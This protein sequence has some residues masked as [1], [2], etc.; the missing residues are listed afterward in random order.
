MAPYFPYT[1]NYNSVRFTSFYRRR[2]RGKNCK[3][4]LKPESS[5][6]KFPLLAF[7]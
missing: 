3:I 7:N 6:W 1:G 5:F 2:V 4:K